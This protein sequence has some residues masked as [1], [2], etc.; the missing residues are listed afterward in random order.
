MDQG[1]IG[2]HIRSGARRKFIEMRTMWKFL[3]FGHVHG[4]QHCIQGTKK[5]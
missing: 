5:G 1:Y 2:E 3:E 4:L